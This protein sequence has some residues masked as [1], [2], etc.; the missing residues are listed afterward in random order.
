MVET[1][2]DACRM[3]MRYLNTPNHA[4]GQERSDSTV[5]IG[6]GQGNKTEFDR[7]FSLWFFCNALAYQ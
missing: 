7:I 2:D 4:A 6:L 5:A 3:A 1:K